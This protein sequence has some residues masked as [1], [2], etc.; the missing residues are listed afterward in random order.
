MA[1]RP[2]RRPGIFRPDLMLLDLGMPGLNG[3][4]AGRRIRLGPGAATW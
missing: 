2:S 1:S 3:Y 4:E